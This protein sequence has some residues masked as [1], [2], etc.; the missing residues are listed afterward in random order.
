MNYAST[1]N[2]A[3]QVGLSHALAQ[4]LAADGGLYVPCTLP[5]FNARDF[6]ADD[7][8]ADVAHRLL[9]PFFADDP[10]AAHLSEICTTALDFPAPLVP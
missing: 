7:S 1:R 9:Q 4:G 2:P 8:L 5:A 6:D 3:T 10:L